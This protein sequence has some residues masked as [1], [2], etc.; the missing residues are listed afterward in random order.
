MAVSDPEHDHVVMKERM[1]GYRLNGRIAR[2]SRVAV[3]QYGA[4]AAEPAPTPAP[5]PKEA[6]EGPPGEPSLEEIVS[7]AQA[8]EALFPDAFEPSGEHDPEE[9]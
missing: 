7:R 1:R 5:V 9:E 2:V 8:Q 6:K 3:G 4:A